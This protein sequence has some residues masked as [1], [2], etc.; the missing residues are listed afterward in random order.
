M[1]FNEIHS[2]TGNLYDH[3]TQTVYSLTL[4]A[5]LLLP[6]QQFSHLSTKTTVKTSSR[7]L[8]R[9]NPI[10]ELLSYSPRFAQNGLC[11]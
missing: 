9:A 4:T 3:S 8:G 5:L 10:F 7:H 1:Y 6:Q 2:A 11:L